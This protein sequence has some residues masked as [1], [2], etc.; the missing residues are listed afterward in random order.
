MSRRGPRIV[1]GVEGKGFLWNMVRIMVGKLA[2]VGIG[3]HPPEAIKAML[4]AKDRT[5]AGPTAPAHGLYLQWIQFKP[6]E[7][8]LAEAEVAR[9]L[10]ERPVQ[11]RVLDDDGRHGS[12]IWKPGTGHRAPGTGNRQT[13]MAGRAVGRPAVSAGVVALREAPDSAPAQRRDQL[14]GGVARDRALRVEPVPGRH[15]G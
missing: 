12:S 4:E 6:M 3:K 15:L 7:Q 9:R 10:S 1:I 14:C 2:H 5:A 13:E 11:D 8:I